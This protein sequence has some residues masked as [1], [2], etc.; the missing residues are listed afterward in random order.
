MIQKIR[1]NAFA[2]NSAILFG[3]TM[4]AS[5]LNYFFHLII[6]RMV[7][8]EI[9]GEIESITSLINILAV[10]AMT[11]AFI[12]TKYAAHSKADK[13][14]Y[15]S[16]EI[17]TYL[18]KKVF[19]YGLPIFALALLA[20][21]LVK[22]FIN[23]NSNIP[24]IFLWIMMLLSFLSAVASGTLNG[25]QK[26]KKTS[27]IGIIATT[28]KVFAA[29]IFLKLGF[30]LSGA[31]G[32]FL[33]GALASYIGSL[34]ALKFI[35]KAKKDPQFND[36]PPINFASIKKYA[37]P[38]L[39]GTLALNILGNA[40][41]VLA[42]HNLD[43]ISAGQYGALTIVS[44]IIFFATGIIATVLFSMSSEKSHQKGDS[45]K[46]F[47]H[48]AFLMLFVS[49]LAIAFYFIFPNFVI[50][51][52]FGN[53]Y[54]D[55]SMYLGWFAI[56]VVLYSFVNLFIQ[57]FLSI[58]KTRVVYGEIAISLTMIPFILLAGRSIY[59]ILGIT[60]VA[61]ILA[62]GWGIFYLYRKKYA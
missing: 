21:P 10:P 60:I 59:A 35:L 34:T 57:Y 4:I 19:K 47:K 3:G 56:L 15:E 18:H 27:V 11:L 12:A 6:G 5:I 53:K 31:I 61:Q 58:H 50:Q 33:V 55:S 13:N 32:G 38:T 30:E 26:F 7:S 23:I 20:T 41:M 14:P 22:N 1:N 48:A 49:I 45:S 44:K 37:L 9:Y 62:L 16:R 29:I 2:M 8:V 46:I 54:V 17:M 42:K 36:A 43:A 52:L 40:D 25:W 24:V 39:L 28:A 51:T